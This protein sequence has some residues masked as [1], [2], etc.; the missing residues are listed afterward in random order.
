[1]VEIQ[2]Q[3]NP[4]RIIDAISTAFGQYKQREEAVLML[5]F[6]ILFSPNFLLNSPGPVCK[7]QKYRDPPGIKLSTHA[8]MRKDTQIFLNFL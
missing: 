5:Q 2:T 6:F 1:M 7:Q 8:R 4:L 3:T